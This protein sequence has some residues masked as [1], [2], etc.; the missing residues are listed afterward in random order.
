MSFCSSSNQVCPQPIKGLIVVTPD[1]LKERA[2]KRAV[3]TEVF[4]RPACSRPH[5]TPEH[6]EAVLPIRKWWR[7]VVLTSPTELFLLWFPPT[8]APFKIFM[9]ELS[10]SLL[11]GFLLWASVVHSKEAE[12]RPFYFHICLLVFPQAV[13]V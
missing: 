1:V 7:G 8:A 3:I 13:V 9:A 4:W 12:R 6:G 5:L 2:E 11:G 10:R